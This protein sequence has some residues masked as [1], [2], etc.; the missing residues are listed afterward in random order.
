M[1]LLD[2]LIKPG[3]QATPQGPT[4]PT[5]AFN[6]EGLLADI[7][8]MQRPDVLTETPSP[9]QGFASKFFGTTDQGDTF[10][11]RLYAFGETMG[12]GD[13]MGYLNARRGDVRAQ[14]ERAEAKAEKERTK[15]EAQADLARR[16]AAFRGAYKGGRFDPEAYMAAM[17]DQGDASEAFSL[18]RALAPKAGVD[19]GTAYTQDPLTGET[20][21]G[22]QRAESPAERLARE[23][24][25]DMDAYRE[26]QIRLREEALGLSRQREG[27]IAAGA[28]ARGRGGAA[29][30]IPAPP[31]GFRIITPG[32]P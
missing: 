20:Q 3:L 30:A 5:K 14:T 2:F 11:D 19:G 13:G 17:G 29:G 31:S 18:A 12:G 21:W 25:E 15:A 9:L 22:D 6:A 4:A 32:G 1:G 8:P 26:E 16:N 24:M 27:R 10:S 28:G 7:G 23:R